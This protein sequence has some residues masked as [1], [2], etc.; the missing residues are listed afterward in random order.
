MDP[1]RVRADGAV[2]RA[3]GHDLLSTPTRP[4]HIVQFYEEESFL[5]ATVADFL[6]AGLSIGEPA[7]VVATK[8]HR[9]AFIRRLRL[10]GLD[11]EHMADAEQLVWLDANEALAGIIVDSLPDRQRFDATIG[12]MV[13]RTSTLH[14]GAVLRMYGEMVD[15]LW[16]RG[17]TEGAIRLEE[18][19]NGLAVQHDFSLL[20][21]YSMGHFYKE[22]DAEQLRAVCGQHT[23]SLPVDRDTSAAD[24]SAPRELARLRQRAQFLE[25]EIEQRKEL[26]RRLRETLVARQTAEEALLVSRREL[27]ELLAER[28]RLLDSAHSAR[29]DAEAANRAKSQFLAVMSHELRTPLNAIAGHV[30]LIEMGIHGAVTPAQAEALRRVRQNQRQLLALINDVLNLVRIESGRVEYAIADV[31]LAPLVH[32]VTSMLEPMIIGSALTCGTSRESSRDHLVAVRADRSKIEQ[33]LLNLLT[34]AIKFT[35]AGGSIAV[36]SGVSSRDAR[37]AYV[38]VRDTG[39]GID[40]ERL[41]EIFEPFVQLVSRPRAPQDGVGLGLAISRDLARGMGGDLSATSVP[42]TGTTFTLSLPRA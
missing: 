2:A 26:E 41:D 6:A 15:L 23:H 20:C 36:E 33:I 25:R 42:G 30:Q 24:G 7:I 19:W 21:A 18:L 14:A 4:S 37:L 28:E 22:S 3:P 13:E 38:R 35:P 8:A 31:P 32:E 9:E 34:N 5:V 12:Q 16:T 29:R 11:P 40:P 17:N 10:E 1:V 39:V 27:E